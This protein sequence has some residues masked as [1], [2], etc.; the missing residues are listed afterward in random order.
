M[1]VG[2]LIKEKSSSDVKLHVYFSRLP[3][4]KLKMEKAL[5]ISIFFVDSLNYFVFLFYFL[6]LSEKIAYL[7]LNKHRVTSC[8]SS[9][10]KS[11]LTV[12][13]E[14]RKVHFNNV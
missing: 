1:A 10:N 5:F 9:Q 8:L 3:F 12:C 7:F 11:S 14:E 13:L 4:S 6:C 2:I